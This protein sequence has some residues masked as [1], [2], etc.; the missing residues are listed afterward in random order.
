MSVDD[1]VARD[2]A[3]VLDPVG[4]EPVVVDAVGVDVVDARARALLVDHG[5]AVEGAE[6]VGDR[7]LGGVGARHRLRVQAVDVRAEARAEQVA[8]VA[9]GARGAPLL[10]ELVGL[11]RDRA[12]DAAQLQDPLERAEVAPGVARDDARRTW[13]TRGSRGSARAPWRSCGRSRRSCPSGSCAGSGGRRAPSGPSGCTAAG[14]GRPA[15]GPGAAAAS[16][17]FRRPS[18]SA[19]SRRRRSRS[20]CC[21]GRRTSQWLAVQN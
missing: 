20:G 4:V 2:L 18:R 10:R 15:A 21:R 5:P 8:R 14:A 1:L 11:G 3:Q 13:P 6:R 19:G 17:P 9:V 12:D 7:V 16:A